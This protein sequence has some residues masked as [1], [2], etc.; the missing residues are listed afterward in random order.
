MPKAGFIWTDDRVQTLR[1]MWIGGATSGAIART[2][3]DG[4]T[5]NAIMGKVNRLGLMGVRRC[6]GA[7]AEAVSHKTE[8]GAAPAKPD[9]PPSPLA[10]RVS[11]L[12]DLVARALGQPAGAVA[13]AQAPREPAASRRRAPRAPA[14]AAATEPFPPQPEAVPSRPVPV[15]EPSP[16]E[17]SIPAR[18]FSWEKPRED[19]RPTLLGLR[20]ESCRWPIGDP[21]R[22]GFHFCGEPA[23]E[24]RP[25]CTEHCG[26]AYQRPDPNR[27]K[28]VWSPMRV[29][30]ARQLTLERLRQGRRRTLARA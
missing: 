1:R 24:P 8:A 7:S 20:A 15:P 16:A 18:Q 12:H 28:V 22:A 3:G 11:P 6:D 10:A 25:Y 2:L 17:E 19:G 21:A 26:L 14:P 30:K 13:A 23:A 5:R 29:A 27:P 9:M 4:V